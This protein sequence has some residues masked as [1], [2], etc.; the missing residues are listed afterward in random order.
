VKLPRDVSGTRLAALLAR[1]GHEV[2]RQTGSHLRRT[3]IVMG[4]THHVTVPRHRQVAVGTLGRIIA[5]V[6]DYLER[7]RSELAEELFAR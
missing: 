1:H 4:D 5:D 7:D 6:A 2:S 3:S